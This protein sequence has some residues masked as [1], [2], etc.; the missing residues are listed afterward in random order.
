YYSTDLGL[1]E[2]PVL[3][4]WLQDS[5]QPKDVFD[6]KKTMVLME[7]LGTPINA[8]TFDLLLASYLLDTNDNSN[9]L[10]ILAQ[11]YDYFDVQ[12]DL[13]VYGK[14]AKRAVPTEQAVLGEHLARKA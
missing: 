12:T 1:L 14:G 2:A 7:R 10:G 11:Q 6:S 8:M 4:N 13:E 5:K 9:D 3:K